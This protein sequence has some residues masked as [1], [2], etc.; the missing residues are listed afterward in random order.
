[1]RFGLYAKKTDPKDCTHM[2]KEVMP[3]Y[4]IRCMWCHTTIRRMDEVQ[5]R[6]HIVEPTTP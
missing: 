4:S 3:D 6:V 2:L 1:M 5:K